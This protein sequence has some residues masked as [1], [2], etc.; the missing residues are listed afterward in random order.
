VAEPS[1]MLA[2]ANSLLLL[3]DSDLAY[4]VHFD[5]FPAVCVAPFGRTEISTLEGKRFDR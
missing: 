1:V 5:Q 4:D 3:K 2:A